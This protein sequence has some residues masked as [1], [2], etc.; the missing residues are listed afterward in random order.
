MY[1][2]GEDQITKP[3]E[4]ELNYVCEICRLEHGFLLP[5]DGQVGSQV[6]KCSYCDQLRHCLLLED[7][8]QMGIE[9]DGK[10]K[11]R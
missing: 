8:D 1:V 3:N 6:T 4:T 2:W 10:R 5:I 7:L 11:K 9:K